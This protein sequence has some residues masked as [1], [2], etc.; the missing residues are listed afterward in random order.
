MVLQNIDAGKISATNYLKSRNFEGGRELNERGS[1]S[2]LRSTKRLNINQKDPT[3]FHI[4]KTDF[5]PFYIH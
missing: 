5:R 4:F 2:S 3:I 1:V